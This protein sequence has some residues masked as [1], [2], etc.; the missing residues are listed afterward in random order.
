[1]PEPGY[2]ANQPAGIAYVLLADEYLNG[3]YTGMT[4]SLITVV[5]V[6]P[7]PIYLLAVYPK[8]QQ[9]ELTPRQR[10]QL[11]DLAAQLKA[12]AKASGKS[13]RLR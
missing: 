4:A 11:T 13:R 10:A 3:V 1:M 5:E 2:A 6:E 12:A 7:F 9:I 8:S